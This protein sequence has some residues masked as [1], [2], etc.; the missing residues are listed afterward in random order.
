MKSA[1]NKY[2]TD[3]GVVLDPKDIYEATTNMVAFYSIVINKEIKEKYEKT[4][5]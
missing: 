1:I 4:Q 5:N 2:Y 3:T